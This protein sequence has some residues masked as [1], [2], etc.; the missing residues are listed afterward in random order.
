MTICPLCHLIFSKLPKT[1]RPKVPFTASR[2]SRPDA[3]VRRSFD[4][5]KHLKNPAEIRKSAKR[6][7]KIFSCKVL[8]SK[9]LRKND[10][11]YPKSA[12]SWR[13][14]V[15]RWRRSVPKT[16]NSKLNFLPKILNLTPHAFKFS[17]GRFEQTHERNQNGSLRLAAAG[18]L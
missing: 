11:S 7:T 15:G 8:N 6:M 5:D 3:K 4:S 16:G 17:A 12:C 18:A 9:T 10:V 14:T 1:C 13:L 2:L